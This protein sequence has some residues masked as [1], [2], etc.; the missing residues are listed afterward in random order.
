M[1]E[2]IA[3]QFKKPSGLL[4]RFISSLMV[5]EN[6]LAYKNLM[7]EMDIKTS[8]VLLEIGFGPGSGIQQIMKNFNPFIIYGID[9]S[10]LMLEQA[11]RLNKEFISKQK[12]ILLFGN[13]LDA[14]IPAVGFDKIYCL[15][16]VYFW[17]ELQ[18][19]FEKI[20]SILKESGSFY[21]FMSSKDDLDKMN[22]TD[23]DIFNK[24]SIEKVEESLMLAGFS[25]VKYYYKNGY[26]ITAI[27]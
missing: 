23:D 15:N 7:N 19:P 3:T 20:R 6:K 18:M 13:F 21:C 8:D 2:R 5:K 24:H 11:S 14:T 16:V 27:K 10:P 4:G 26:F 9:F 22:F 17:D 1:L 25:K 12:V